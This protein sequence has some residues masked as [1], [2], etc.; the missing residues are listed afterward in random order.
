MYATLEL[1]IA[2]LAITD[3]G[4]FVETG[5]F[6][7]GTASLMILALL[8]FDNCGRKF[9]GFDSFEGLPS[10]SIEDKSEYGV[11]MAQG[12]L[13]FD[14]DS[15]VKNLKDWK[16]WDEKV[17][18]LTKGYFNETLPKSTVSQISFLRLDGDL[19]VSTWDA[20]VNLYP[21]VTPGG[22]VY[23]DDYGS[24]PGCRQAV[25]QYRSKHHIFEPLHFVRDT[26]IMGHIQFEAVW[27][28][29]RKHSKDRT[30]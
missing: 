7:G 12:E 9:W 10:S 30:L 23:I 4:D 17:V 29:K 1:C 19:F 15:V 14:Y 25:D 20:L 3:S 18:I 26:P 28:Q 21:K 5:I 27:W 6:T 11:T 24:F 8:E 16:V 22:F 13:S 2:A